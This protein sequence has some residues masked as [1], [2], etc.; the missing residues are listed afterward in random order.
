M[1]VSAIGSIRWL[2]VRSLVLGG[3][4]VRVGVTITDRFGM[5]GDVRIMHGETT[6][7]VGQLAIDAVE[8]SAAFEHHRGFGPIRLRGGL[9]AR[10]AIAQWS[11]TVE[12]PDDY[13]VETQR[14]VWFGPI[15]TA[16][17]SLE[18]GRHF[19]AGLL[20]E[21]GYTVVGFGAL[22]NNVRETALEGPWLSGDVLVGARW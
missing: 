20:A 4:G 22:V 19:E 13:H 11:G 16:G 17:V 6:V 8:T 3:G 1:A 5:L 15:V 18:L 2:P 10:A 9:G 7:S 12:R 21:A 14:G